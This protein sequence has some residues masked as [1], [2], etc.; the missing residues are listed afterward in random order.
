MTD[1][2]AAP[3]GKTW[4]D[5]ASTALHYLAAGVLVGAIGLFAY[6]GKIGADVF[7]NLCVA[8]LAGLG[9]Y[10]GVSK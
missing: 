7:T 8:A 9:V 2:T 4:A 5:V 3:S 6:W 10:K 1:T